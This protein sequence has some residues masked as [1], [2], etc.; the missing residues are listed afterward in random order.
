MTNQEIQQIVIDKIHTL[1]HKFSEVNPT[2]KVYVPEIK[3]TKRGKVAGCVTYK[4][5]CDP[6]IN[7]NM[8]LLKDNLEHFVKQTVTH[9][10]AHFVTW[11][12]YGHQRTAGG[13]RIIH[14]TDWKNMMKFFGVES[15]R[16]HSYNTA[17]S[18]VRKM[19]R[20]TYKCD[21]ME[22]ELTIIRHNKIQKG[23]A[24]YCCNKCKTKL[25]L[26]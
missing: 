19:K 5:G 11:I 25:T 17:K 15:E 6:V 3:F 1:I 21:C 24:S 12:K 10:V 8:V 26:V 18:T 4:L 9:E 22:H 7:F 2:K 20:F 23:S 14:G 16:C 13:K